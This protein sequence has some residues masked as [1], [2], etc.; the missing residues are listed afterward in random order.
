MK[1]YKDAQEFLADV[2]EACTQY[3]DGLITDKESLNKIIY[4]A[5]CF[6]GL[7]TEQA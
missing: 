2:K 5:A 6:L 3:E 7:T 4:A 1:D